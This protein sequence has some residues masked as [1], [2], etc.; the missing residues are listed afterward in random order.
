MHGRRQEPCLVPSPC[1][2]THNALPV[3]EGQGGRRVQAADVSHSCVKR[4]PGLVIEAPSFH[5]TWNPLVAVQTGLCG[6]HL[7]LGPS[8]NSLSLQLLLITVEG[9]LTPLSLGSVVCTMGIRTPAVW[10]DYLRLYVKY[11]AHCGRISYLF[12]F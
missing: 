4:K 3:P 11:T 6:K 12:V 7:G 1:P 9:C 5:T 8:R 10:E 2:D